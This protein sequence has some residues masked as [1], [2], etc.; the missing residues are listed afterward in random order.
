MHD[1]GQLVGLPNAFLLAGAKSVIASLWRVDDRATYLLM[2][3]FYEAWAGG[4]GAEPSSA[5]A[6]SAARQRLRRTDRAVALQLLGPGADVPGRQ[7]PFDH[8]AYTDAFHCH[9]GW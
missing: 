2:R 4:T 8:P 9:G 5:V 1:G 3:Y 6:L 7:F